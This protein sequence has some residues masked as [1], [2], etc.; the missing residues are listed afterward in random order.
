MTTETSNRGLQGHYAMKAWD[1]TWKMH[2]IPTWARPRVGAYMKWQRS[3]NI[4][5]TIDLFEK[6]N[7]LVRNFRDI[8]DHW[9][10]VQGCCDRSLIMCPYGRHDD[11]AVELAKVIA[12]GSWTCTSGGPWHPKTFL[13]TFNLR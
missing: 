6:E 7:W 3:C 13:Y 2:H 10:S 12:A 11:V 1:A 5:L 8:C 4:N 9:G